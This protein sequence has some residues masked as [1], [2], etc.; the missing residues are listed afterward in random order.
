MAVAGPTAKCRRCS[1]QQEQEQHEHEQQQQQQQLQLQLLCTCRSFTFPAHPGLLY[2]PTAIPASL[3][4]YLI[5]QAL[6]QYPEPPARTNHWRAYGPLPGIFAAAQQGLRCAV[7]PVPLDGDAGGM[8]SSSG[9]TTDGHSTTTPAV[10]AAA[11][12]QAAADAQHEP[13]QASKEQHGSQYHHHNHHHHRHALLLL[14]TSCQCQHSQPPPQPQQPE[15]HPSQRAFHNAWCSGGKG[16]QASQLL[17]KLRWACL[18]PR[19]DW[20]ARVYDGAAEHRPLPAVLR[21]IAV[22]AAAAANEAAAA[23]G[24]NQA[25][26]VAGAAAAGAAVAVS[27]AVAGVAAADMAVAGAAAC[28]AAGSVIGGH[29]VSGAAAVVTGATAPA[30]AFP[31]AHDVTVTTATAPPKPHNPDA[32]IIN[33]YYTG[34]T[35]GGHQDNVEKD[36]SQPIISISL[37]CDAVFLM[38]GPSK[39]Q[40]PTALLLKSGDVLVMGGASRGC[41]HGVPRV[42]TERG[43]PEELLAAAGMA[44]PGAAAAGAGGAAARAG[45]AIAGTAAPA[46]G[47][48][49]AAAGKAATAGPVT[50]MAGQEQQQLWSRAHVMHMRDARINISIRSTGCDE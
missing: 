8:Y 50:E 43:L 10:A 11:E 2:L 13:L 33:Y 36:G 5:S 34:D 41:Y 32:A 48:E 18:G 26:A 37:G 28:P 25:A 19:F 39:E 27:A 42:L 29:A 15:Q 44:G 12:V 46:L 20:T 45:G 17:R 49:G 7:T 31:A 35:L 6:E 30:A 9:H 3:Q 24:A 4:L 47:A 22:E 14:P 1:Q 16:T 23:A 21:A 40:R 38:G